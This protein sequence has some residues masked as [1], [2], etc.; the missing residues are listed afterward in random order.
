VALTPLDVLTKHGIDPDKAITIWED[1]KEKFEIR[2]HG[3]RYMVDSSDT[4]ITVRADNN[5]MLWYISTDQQAYRLDDADWVS[6]KLPAGREAQIAL[7]LVDI[8]A[9]RL[10]DVTR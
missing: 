2:A 10:R 3:P 1:L 7:A 4:E 5:P 9:G 8:S 6:G